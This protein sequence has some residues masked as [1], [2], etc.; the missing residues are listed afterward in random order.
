MNVM[1]KLN[2]GLLA[3]VSVCCLGSC[4]EHQRKTEST[5][6]EQT[7]SKAEEKF[8]KEKNYTGIRVYSGRI[9][10]EDCSGIEQR[11]VLKGDTVGIYRL[12]EVY[13][14]ATEDGDAVLV[15]TGE[16]EFRGK[17]K[18]EPEILF[19]SQGHIG[20]SVR[21]ASYEFKKDRILQLELNG[22]SV[23]NKASYSLRLLKHS[24]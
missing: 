8:I 10:C 4:I 23:G 16:W 22:D 20:D 18:K 2:I 3:F 9:P 11:L 19:L 7:T 12:T 5:K 6:S 14:D 21:V 13:K 17:N 24:R 1:K 15:S